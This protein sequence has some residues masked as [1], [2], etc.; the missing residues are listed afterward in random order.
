MLEQLMISFTN[1]LFDDIIRKVIK[2]K[3]ELKT[4]RWMEDE[5]IDRAD[6]YQK[7]QNGDFVVNF[8]N[9]EGIDDDDENSKVKKRLSPL[10]ALILSLS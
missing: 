6:D 8:R 5:H 2:I 7:L 10:G 1:S 3:H 9:D 4:E